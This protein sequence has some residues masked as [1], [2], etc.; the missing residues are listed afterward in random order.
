MFT[1][2]ETLKACYQL[3]LSLILVVQAVILGSVISVEFFSAYRVRINGFGL[4]N[5]QID[6]EQ[7][8]QL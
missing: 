6:E 7:S 1:A 3:P 2:G 8:Q 4:S 5:R